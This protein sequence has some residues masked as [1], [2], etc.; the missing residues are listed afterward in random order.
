MGAATCVARTAPAPPVSP[1]SRPSGV[2]PGACARR[3]ALSFSPPAPAPH[4][5]RY[6]ALRAPTSPAHCS[7]RQHRL[8]LRVEGLLHLIEQPRHLALVA[9]V[10]CQLRRDNQPMLAIDG[11]LRVAALP[12]PLG[13]GLHD[14]AVRVGEV[15]LVFGFPASAWLP[16]PALPWRPRASSA[17][18]C[19]ARAFAAT[20]AA[21]RS[22]RRC[23]SSGNSSPRS[24][25]PKRASSSASVSRAC[26]AS[27]ASTPLLRAHPT[28]AYRLALA[29]V[30][31]NPVSFPKLKSPVSRARRTTS[32]NN[33]SNS[34][35][36]RR[37]NSHSVRWS[38]PPPETPR[39]PPASSPS[40]ATPPSHTR[41][42]AP[43]PSSEA[44]TG[45]DRHPHTVPPSDPARPPSRS[46][47]AQSAL[48]EANPAH[49]APA[50]AS[51]PADVVGLSPS[52]PVRLLSHHFLRRTLLDNDQGHS[53]RGTGHFLDLREFCDTDSGQAATNPARF[54][55]KRTLT[56]PNQVRQE[57][58][59]KTIAKHFPMVQFC[60]DNEILEPSRK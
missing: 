43:R 27:I 12:E 53:S 50:A 44:H 36:C 1:A 28:V 3:G 25:S 59:W 31:P 49:P 39:P 54:L 4:T 17:S 34:S 20:I 46:R 45:R 42:A 41:R 32:T 55:W 35:R 29:R 21:N 37:R 15:A 5:R 48:P 51:G 47:D 24:D 11:H 30:R 26:S 58:M 6:P 19:A 14:G 38:S 10:R 57:T 9:R 56:E 18:R 40:P 7:S 23:N 2:S 22:S 8:G 52:A 33:P 16:T 60:V 13:A